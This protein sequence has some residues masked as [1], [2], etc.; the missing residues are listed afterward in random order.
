[1]TLKNVRGGYNN[2]DIPVILF[3]EAKKQSAE[4]WVLISSERY[5]DEIEAQLL[6]TMEPNYIY[7]LEHAFRPRGLFAM[8]SLETQK[9]IKRYTSMVRGE[10]PWKKPVL[11]S[12][13]DMPMEA[14][15][16]I[17]QLEEYW[18]AYEKG[19]DMELP[20]DN[21]YIR[22]EQIDFFKATTYEELDTVNL[23]RVSLLQFLNQPSYLDCWKVKGGVEN[24]A[25]LLY[26]ELADSNVN[27]NTVVE[28]IT[29]FHRYLQKKNIPF[30]YVQLPNKLSTQDV[31]LPDGVKDSLNSEATQLVS[32]LQSGGV[33]ILDYRE[34]MR[35]RNIQSFDAFYKTDNHWKTKTAFDAVPCICQEL[36]RLY[37]IPFVEEQFD[38]NN[39]HCT[40][41]PQIF[42][43]ERGQIPGLLYSGLDDYELI[44]PRYETDYSWICKNFNMY[45]RGSAEEALLFHP[46]L[47]WNFYDLHQYGVYAGGDY[48]HLQIIN[49][50]KK[51]TG[52]LLCIHDSFTKPMAMFLAPHFSELHFVDL[53]KTP[54]GKR[55]VDKQD[56][57]QLLEEI[58][59]DVV[60]MMY[61]PNEILRNE[62]TT[63]VN[64]NTE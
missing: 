14:K 12:P 7:N 55:G 1:M 10:I 58:N 36:N 16:T 25:H 2:G 34:V 39:Y 20:I 28:N 53:R 44:L 64:P 17:A 52:K 63:D 21:Y 26:G 47:D 3:E 27:L 5:G 37:G 11:K 23:D 15:K 54:Q 45:K 40:I 43:G 48:N 31:E 13:E 18:E 29:E 33:A 51:K 42:M 4:L 8:S 56:L 50:K 19:V 24:S 60:L 32:Q 62:L 59:F 46:H 41:Y 9:K 6:N 30:L 49:H 35:S 61:Y 22:H 57:F 38:I